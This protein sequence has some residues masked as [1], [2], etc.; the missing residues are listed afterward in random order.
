ML[1]TS[2]ISAEKIAVMVGFSNKNSFWREFQ[3]KYG[4]TPMEYRKL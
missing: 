2:D 4:V 3:K 1:R